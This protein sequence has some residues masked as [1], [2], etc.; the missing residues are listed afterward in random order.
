MACPYLLEKENMESSPKQYKKR[1]STHPQFGHF[2][3]QGKNCVK[4]AVRIS[5]VWHLSLLFF[6]WGR[7]GKKTRYVTQ[8]RGL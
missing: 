8:E 6:R 2:P 5:V 7:R 1:L 4:K 3:E